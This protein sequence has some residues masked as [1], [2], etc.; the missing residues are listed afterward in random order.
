VSDWRIERLRRSYAA[1]ARLDVDELETLYHPD[2]EWDMGPMAVTSDQ[3]VWRGHEG[4]RAMCEMID[5]EFDSMTTELLE[6]R[7]VSDDRVLVRG[8]NL[9]SMRNPGEAF[10]ALPAPYGQIVDFRDDLIA[11]VTQTDDP[12]PGWSEAR[13]IV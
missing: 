12:P 5:R 2:C 9:F 8:S 3:P 6:V 1:F 7:A 4:L 11:R 10:P 13:A